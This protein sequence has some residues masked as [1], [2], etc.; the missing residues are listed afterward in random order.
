MFLRA[1][2]VCLRRRLVVHAS[3]DH[4]LVFRHGSLRG[5]H[6]HVGHVEGVLAAKHRLLARDCLLLHLHLLH[7]LLLLHE[8]GL[9][10][11]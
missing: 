3:V 5:R 10:I 9:A 2:L 11:I 1:L 7:L 4:L 8:H 6:L